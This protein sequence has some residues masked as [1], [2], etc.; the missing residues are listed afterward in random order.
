MVMEGGWKKRLLV[1]SK[2]CV[3]TGRIGRKDERGRGERKGKW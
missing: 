1:L 3:V 2:D